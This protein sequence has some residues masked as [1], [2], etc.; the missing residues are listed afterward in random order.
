MML[1]DVCLSDVCREHPVGGRRVRPASWMARIGWSGPARPAWL[2]AARFRNRPG[3]GISWR[4]PAYSLLQPNIVRYIYVSSKNSVFLVKY[5]AY[6][7]IFII[8]VTKGTDWLSENCFGKSPRDVAPLAPRLSNRTRASCLRGCMA[9]E[10]SPC[11]AT[12]LCY[13]SRTRFHHCC[14]CCCCWRWCSCCKLLSHDVATES[15]LAHCLTTRES[16]S[17][18][19]ECDGLGTSFNVWRN[20]P[21]IL[22]S[23]RSYL[24]KETKYKQEAQLMLT[25]GSTRL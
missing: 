23:E 18:L 25:T 15:H 4:P 14:C 13:V 2:K 7:W 8:C 10:I 11:H 17:F 12:V 22:A 21:V 20:K 5:P 19:V 6:E 16:R 24:F 1:S 3:R 9:Y